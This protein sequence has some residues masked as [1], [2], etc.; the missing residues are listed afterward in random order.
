MLSTGN[1]HI[2]IQTSIKW[3]IQKIVWHCIWVVVVVQSLSCV[4][5]FVT[6]RTG[7][8]QAPLSMRFPRQESWSGLPFPS[9]R[10]LPDPG[11]EPVSP[12]LAGGFFTAE[13]PGKSIWVVTGQWFW[14]EREERFYT[15]PRNFPG[16]SDAKESACSAGDIGLIPGLGR[17][18]VKGN[19]YP[20]QYSCLE[21]PMDRGAWWATTACG[22]A[23]SE[24]NWAHTYTWDIWPCLETF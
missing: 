16:G 15:Y 1:I 19:A 21:N 4:W 18:P 17:S 12:V 20:F 7:T 2:Y 11:I 8:H 10:G 5:L 13:P 22:V 3:T 23:E 24:N 14:T 9:P 6:P